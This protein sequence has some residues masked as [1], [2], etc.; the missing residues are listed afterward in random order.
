MK[1][2]PQK[3]ITTLCMVLG[4]AL[5]GRLAHA[6]DD[7]LPPAWLADLEPIKDEFRVRPERPRLYINRDD[8]PVIRSRA[9]TSHQE[10]WQSVNSISDF[11]RLKDAWYDVH[12]VYS[13]TNG[14]AAVRSNRLTDRILAHAFQY[15]ITNE[16]SHAREAIDAALE[17]SADT[18][19]DDLANAYRVWPESVAF[20]WCH[21]HLR[22]GEGQKLLENVRKQ[23]KIVDA[24][25]PLEKSALHM[26]HLVNHLADAFLPAGIAFYDEA[27]EIFERA[28]KVACSE[29][30]AKNVFY[31]SGLSSQGDSYGLT[32]YHGDIRMLAML[33]KATG[34]D[35]FQRFPF[36]RD[37]GY[38]WVYTRRPDGQFLRLGDEWMDSQNV[39]VWDPP[40]PWGPPWL[41]E[42]LAYAAGAYGDAH[43]AY[44]YLKVRNLNHTWVAI[45]DILWRDP[46]VEPRS[47]EDLPPVRYLDGAAGTLLFRTG[48]GPDD[49]VG[50]FKAMPLY[51]KNHDHLDRLSFQ[52]YCRGALAIDSG[53]YEGVDSGYGSPHWL[54]YLQ[55]TIAHNSLLIRDPGEEVLYRGRKVV[56]DGGQRFPG[57][58]NDPVSLADLRDP[59]W[60]IAR[61]LSHGEDQELGRYAFVSAD[62]TAGYGPKAEKVERSFVFLNGS[63]SGANPENVVPKAT[64]VI[65]DR[66]VARNPGHQ[67]VWL[68]HSLEEPAIEGVKFTIKNS[69]ANYGGVLLSHSLLPRQAR[70]DKVGGPGKEFWVNDTNYGTSKSGTCE[71]GAWRLEITPQEADRA[72]DFLHVFQ[73]YPRPPAKAPVP[74][75]VEGRGV[76]GAELLDRTVIFSTAGD[77]AR[78]L[79]YVSVGTGQREH[80]VI[81]LPAGKMANVSAGG[82]NTGQFSTG[83]SG[84]LTFRIDQQGRTEFQIAVE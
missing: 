2:T 68:F 40:A 50:L 47:P 83:P 74:L 76:V 79:Q 34:V 26:G 72:V 49:V 45:T 29:I 6:A 48:W 19:G 78:S 80:L 41:M 22:P 27:P 56:A 20:D 28:I 67:I 70:I 30:V 21:A 62:A 9:A 4:L 46:D 7:Q 55:R 32:H 33:K 75:S 82:R 16:P 35:L 36:Y 3:A 81:G 10:A 5:P 39:P 51:V 31:R 8:L 43:L 13:G 38:Y 66:V 65:R 24:E 58:G 18:K 77:G 71:A 15:L 52:I 63:R 57:V 44:E 23:L 14:N 42:A 53:I 64:I 12:S 25:V 61:V 17:L 11:S 60:H 59:L 37:V 54:N 69:G 73:V 84:S 1:C